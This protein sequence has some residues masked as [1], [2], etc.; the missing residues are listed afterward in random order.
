[1]STYFHLIFRYYKHIF[2]HLHTYAPTV[3]SSKWSIL[4][5]VHLDP[6]FHV[7]T[8]NRF[9]V[10]MKI[11]LFQCRK[12]WATPPPLPPPN[13]HTVGVISQT[14]SMNM[15]GK[16]ISWFWGPIKRLIF[17]R[18]VHWT[19]LGNF[20]IPWGVP[21]GGYISQTCSSNFDTKIASFHREPL[22]E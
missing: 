21:R 13:T 22:G 12:F 3:R 18:H 1:M 10:L 20:L 16:N 19:C 2:S 11:K 5:Q 6:L 14:C 8:R 15:S 4:F 7:Q 9:L 17:P